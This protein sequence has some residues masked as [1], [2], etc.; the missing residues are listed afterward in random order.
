MI[1]GDISRT[2]GG[3]LQGKK[4]RQTTRRVASRI[5]SRSRRTQQKPQIVKVASPSPAPSNNHKGPSIRHTF[6]NHHIF[7]HACPS[8]YYAHSAT[9][10][11]YYRGSR[12]TPPPRAFMRH[13]TN[14]RGPRA[15]ERER[16]RDRAKASSLS[17][18]LTLF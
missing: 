11:P 10:R 6:P 12:L 9:I 4:M 2:C 3:I 16:E 15:R 8:H 1:I 18:S 7:I 13:R 14:G 5:A 17:L